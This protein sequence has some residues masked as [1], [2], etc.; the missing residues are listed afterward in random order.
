MKLDWRDVSS[1]FFKTVQPNGLVKPDIYSNSTGDYDLGMAMAAATC[2]HPTHREFGVTTGKPRVVGFFDCVA[3]CEMMDAQGPLCS[4]GAL[5]R[6]DDYDEYGVCIAYVFQHP[7]GKSMTS[8]GKEYK[9][10]SIIRAGDQLPTQPILA[11]CHP[12]VK[13]IKGWR[14]TPIYA[15]GDWWKN[16]K[17][18][19]ELPQHVCEFLD[20]IEHFTGSKIISIG[21]GPKGDEIVYIEKCT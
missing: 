19:V 6:G 2:I 14:D 10:G 8:N 12:V 3:H 18:P 9:S 20:I 11:Y 7:E 1:R 4:L 16:R 21:N 15:G 17:Q 5:D 13:V